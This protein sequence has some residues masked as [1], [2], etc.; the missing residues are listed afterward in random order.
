MMAPEVP[1]DRVE[2]MRSA[3]DATMKDPEF[4]ADSAKRKLDIRPI[5]GA[6]QSLLVGQTLATERHVVELVKRIV[7]DQ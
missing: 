3:F 5:R 2:A 7:G 6:E 1:A 4:L